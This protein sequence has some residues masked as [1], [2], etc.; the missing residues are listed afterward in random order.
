[1]D[2][3][4]ATIADLPGIMD[5][6]KAMHA[7]NG[8]LRLSVA[9]T[10]AK[11]RHA[12]ENG[13]VVVAVDQGKIVGSVAVLVGDFSWYSEE[14]IVVDLWMFVH[15]KARRGLRVFN[16]LM[17]AFRAYKDALNLPLMTAVVSPKDSA[18]KSD[19]YRRLLTSVGETFI[20]MPNPTAA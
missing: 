12:L 6:L 4:E 14:R 5:L 11:A 3:R 17:T 2:L 18:R 7:E 8:I 13:F 1:M 10:E 20:E 16:Q 9:K 15:P 19:L